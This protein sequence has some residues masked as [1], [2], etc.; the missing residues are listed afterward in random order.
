MKFIELEN[1]EIPVARS[2]FRLPFDERLEHGF[3]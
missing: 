3:Q 2:G 1:R